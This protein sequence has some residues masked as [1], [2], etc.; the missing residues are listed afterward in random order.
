[1]TALITTLCCII[2]ATGW[3]LDSIRSLNRMKKVYQTYQA[4]EK[5]IRELME[6]N[7]QLRKELTNNK[8]KNSILLTDKEEKIKDLENENSKLTQDLV[9]AKTQLKTAHNN[10]RIMMVEFNRAKQREAQK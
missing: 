2:T 5:T 3:A 6:D 7:R 4:A 1:M 9:E 8:F 10:L